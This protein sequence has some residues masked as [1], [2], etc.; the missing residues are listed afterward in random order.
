MSAHRKLAA[1]LAADVSGHSRLTG[2]DEECTLKRRRKLRR[3][4]I[5]R[6]DEVIE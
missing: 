1:I 2:L 6:A 3:E 4:L 5:A